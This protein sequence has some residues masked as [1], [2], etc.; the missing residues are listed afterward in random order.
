MQSS[1]KTLDTTQ[2]VQLPNI[3]GCKICLVYPKVNMYYQRQNE[4]FL[5]TIRGPFN[6]LGIEARCS[7]LRL[8]LSN[9]IILKPKNKKEI[10]NQ[11]DIESSSS[12]LFLPLQHTKS[13]GILRCYGKKLDSFHSMHIQT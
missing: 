7:S 11:Q 1:D 8:E 12:S 10:S 13:N 4:S 2:K 9:Q 5:L 6:E 3:S